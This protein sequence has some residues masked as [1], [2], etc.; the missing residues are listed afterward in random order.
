MARE[1]LVSM[2]SVPAMWQ[3]GGRPPGALD[4]FAE[5]PSVLEYSSD[6]LTVRPGGLL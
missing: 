4:L 3:R 6:T 1:E 2:L 5:L